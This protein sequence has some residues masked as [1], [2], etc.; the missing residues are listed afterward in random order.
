MGFLYIYWIHL[1]EMA[2]P[3]RQAKTCLGCVYRSC[4]CLRITQT[5]QSTGLQGAVQIA[6]VTR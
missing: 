5:L 1:E 4:M 2:C 6:A 3:Y